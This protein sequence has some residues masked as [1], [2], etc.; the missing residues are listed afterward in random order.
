MLW[1]IAWRNLWRQR[2]RTLTMLSAVA[3]SYALMLVGMAMSDDSHAR[4]LDEAARMAG[5][6]V[7]VHGDGYWATRASDLVV[8]DAD[9]ALDVVRGVDG[10]RAALPRIIVNGLAGTSS[11]TRPILLYGIDPALEAEMRDPADDLVEGEFLG[12]RGPNDREDAGTPGDRGAGAVAAEG[13][14]GD[15]GGR[16][17]S[18]AAGAP[19]VLGARL[20]ERLEVTPGDRVVLT[21]TDPDG[22]IT[23]ALFH[24]AGIVA[25]GARQLDELVG[26]TT[27]DAARRALGMD[28]MLT[29]VGVLT[30]EGTAADIVARRVEAALGDAAAAAGGPDALEVLT[31]REAVPEMVGL[32]EI[33]D[34]FSLIIVGVLYAVVLFSI[35]NTFLMAV[36][37]RVREFGLLNALGMRD[38]RI[39]RL[40][41]AETTLLVALA[42]G[43]GLVLALGGHLALDHWGINTA[44][45]GVEE[46]EMAGVDMADMVVHSRI[47]PVKWI[48][49]S[50][51]VAL[52]TIASALYPA[53]RASRLAPAEAM[54]FY[55]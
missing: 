2:T 48:A 3:L 34:A 4:M 29:Q 8:R 54:R 41:L 44:M 18:G 51:I 35:T 22:E 53:W 33:D 39:G 15:E 9:R 25:T 45:Y 23:R 24:L 21:A 52:A 16:A 20:A 7:L 36:M 46:L 30:P 27:L 55:E 10:V 6:D 1:R 47:V 17:G 19:I 42:L 5:G 40:L 43:V 32:L 31:W 13:G 38:G 37:E 26:Y 49:G 28:G 50:V 14:G 12:V 11:D